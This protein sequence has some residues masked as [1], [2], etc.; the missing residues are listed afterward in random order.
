MREQ[1]RA[2]ALQCSSLALVS[3]QQS[4]D[5]FARRRLLFNLRMLVHGAR[6]VRLKIQ[7]SHNHQMN[8]LC[9]SR[10][11]K[12]GPSPKRCTKSQRKWKTS[13]ACAKGCMIAGSSNKEQSSY[14]NVH[15]F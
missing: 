11:L 2:T 14:L 1:A 10:K 6:I 5:V 15:V 4:Y 8:Q 7:R 3:H 13:R 9:E 12:S